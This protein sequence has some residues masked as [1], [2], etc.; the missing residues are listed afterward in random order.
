MSATGDMHKGWKQSPSGEAQVGSCVRWWPVQNRSPDVSSTP[1]S[2]VV[3]D[4]SMWV[5]VSPKAGP[6]PGSGKHEAEQRM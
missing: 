3:L 6:S 5:V 4:I 2:S 1:L